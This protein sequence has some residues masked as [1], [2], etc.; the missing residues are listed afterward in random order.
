[1]RIEKCY[2]DF[3]RKLRERRQWL[4]LTQEEVA[5]IAGLTRASIVNIEAGRQRAHYHTVLLLAEN[6]KIQLK[7]IR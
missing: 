2:R 7:G 4:G 5:W 6:L 3:G 1:M